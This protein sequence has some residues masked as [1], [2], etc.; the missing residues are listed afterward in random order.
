MMPLGP[1]FTEVQ[2]GYERMKNEKKTHS[3]PIGV[4]KTDLT[5]DRRRIR[6]S[7]AEYSLSSRRSTFGL[8][9]KK[10]AFRGF[11]S[12]RIDVHSK[13]FNWH[14]RIRSLAEIVREF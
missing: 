9:K 6:F 8:D 4:P 1:S 5:S 3:D 7:H 11:P 13:E 14:R 2:K 12:A 10:A